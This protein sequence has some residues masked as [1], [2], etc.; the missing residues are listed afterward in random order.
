MSKIASHLATDHTLDIANSMRT[1][2]GRQPTVDQFLEAAAWGEKKKVETAFA[3]T[4]FI[5]SSPKVRNS[6][7]KYRVVLSTPMRDAMTEF[8]NAGASMQI[9]T[10]NMAYEMAS[11]QCYNVSRHLV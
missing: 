6:F 4:L 2:L 5:C 9:W 8:C 3:T 10:L 11:S 7:G 1:R